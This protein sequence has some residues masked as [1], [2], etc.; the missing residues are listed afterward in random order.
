MTSARSGPLQ[1][2]PEAKPRARQQQHPSRTARSPPRRPVGES[3]RVTCSNSHEFS[4]CQASRF[5]V[6]PTYRRSAAAA[7]ANRDASGSDERARGSPPRA[8]GRPAQVTTRRGRLLQRLVG[9]RWCLVARRSSASALE[10]P[11]QREFSVAQRALIPVVLDEI[12]FTAGRAE[13]KAR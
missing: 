9:R 10:V 3:Q 4:R 12:S 1:A 7:S 8:T 2:R 6:C 11:G 13:A 5:P